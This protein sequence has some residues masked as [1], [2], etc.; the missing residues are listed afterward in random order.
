MLIGLMFA[1][2]MYLRETDAPKQMSEQLNPLYRFLLN[3]WYFDEL[4]H[5]IFVR[6][7]FALGRLF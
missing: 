7:A 4:Y 1:S 3:K 2:A 5:L 6:P